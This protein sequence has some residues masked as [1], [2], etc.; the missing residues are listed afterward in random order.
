MDYTIRQAGD[1]DAETIM[2]LVRE[3]FRTVAE[4]FGLTPENSPRHP[5]NCSIEWVRTERAS[6]VRYFLLEVAGE[7]VGC[8]AVEPGDPRVCHIERLAVLPGHR[9][10]GY[11]RALVDRALDAGREMGVSRMELSIISAN[12]ELR[13]WYEAMEFQVIGSKFVKHLAFEVTFM[14]KDL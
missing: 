4:R 8:V 1:D 3:S 9:G 13:Q 5:S 7:P 11:G 6:G 14:A 2:R 12:A 10:K